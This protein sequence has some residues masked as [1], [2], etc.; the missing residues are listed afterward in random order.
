MP[1]PPDTYDV[2]YA[3]QKRSS[4]VQIISPG[5]F[6]HV[7]GQVRVI[8]KQLGLIFH[9]IACKWVRDCNPQ[10]WIQ[11]GAD[12]NHSVKNG[13]LGAWNTDGLQGLYVIQLQVV[14][15]DQRVE[16]DIIQLT[17]DNIAPQIQILA[18][19]PGEEFTYQLGKSI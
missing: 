2:I 8:G 5:T 7:K 9:I 19:T 12:I 17:V 13:L 10:Q 15:K 18:P 3:K 16:Y 4:D 11:I 1:I 14:R 6:D